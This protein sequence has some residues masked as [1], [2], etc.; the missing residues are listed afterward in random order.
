MSSVIRFF[1]LALALVLVGISAANA[2]AIPRAVVDYRRH[3]VNV[4]IVEETRSI[5][6]VASSPRFIARRREVR[7][8]RVPNRL[9]TRQTLPR[10]ELG[11]ITD[12]TSTFP[13]EERGSGHAYAAPDSSTSNKA[14][15]RDVT[16]PYADA[17]PTL[18]PRNEAGLV[19]IDLLNTYF[20]EMRAQ[21]RNLRD[22]SRRARD[23][24]NDPRFRDNTVREL[25]GFRDNMGR[26]QGLLGDLGRD[27]GLA[28]YDRNNDLE[29]LLKDI[30]NLNKDAL[31]SVTEIV[32]E[33]PLLGP[34]LGPIVG[35]LKCIIDEV[36]NAVENTVDGLLNSLGVTGQWRGLR[37]N[38]VSALCEG[39]LQLLGL[40]VDTNLSGLGVRSD[41]NR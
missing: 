32:Y 16:L 17:I 34:I 30:V 12:V 40:C 1:S 26:A 10:P 41:E 21:S 31:S 18:L 29:T 36:L 25:R 6:S 33:I 7:D 37:G 8:F 35:E 38:Y 39:N 3:D 14:A 5:P 28:N 11:D 19:Q 27:K 20:R 4:R 15:P 13:L 24:R 23:S 2:Y 22:Y 9:R